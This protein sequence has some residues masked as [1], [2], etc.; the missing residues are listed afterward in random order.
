M[1]AFDEKRARKVWRQTANWM[2]GLSMAFWVV[3]IP[4]VEPVG[5]DWP[6]VLGWLGFW[7]LLWLI[8][9]RFGRSWARGLGDMHAH[10]CLRCGRVVKKSRFMHYALPVLRIE[11]IDEE[12]GE[13]KLLW[14]FA[15]PSQLREISTGQMVTF[16]DGSHL[17]RSMEWAD[18]PATLPIRPGN[19]GETPG[20][21]RD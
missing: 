16:L 18:I 8:M 15:L 14:C 6:F 1:E 4:L 13:A 20:N 5:E 17:R 3:F 2:C 19:G 21:V 10:G 7:G 9:L 12:T 11:V